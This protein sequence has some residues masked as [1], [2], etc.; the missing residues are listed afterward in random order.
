MTVPQEWEVVGSSSLC[1]PVAEYSSTG[2]ATWHMEVMYGLPTQCNKQHSSLHIHFVCGRHNPKGLYVRTC[3]EAE[4][5]GEGPPA[6]IAK[7]VLG[8]ISADWKARKIFA[9]KV[10]VPAPV[11]PIVLA[12]VQVVRENLCRNLS[13]VFVVMTYHIEAFPGYMGTLAPDP[14]MQAWLPVKPPSPRSISKFPS[15]AGAPWLMA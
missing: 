3:D 15:A 10:A 7:V 1:M 5:G 11:V 13:I 9:P 14:M 2:H 8:T 6:E 4:A 12:P